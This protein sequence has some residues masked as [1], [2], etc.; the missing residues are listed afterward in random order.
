MTTFVIH[1]VNQI[2]FVPYIHINS[3]PYKG[4]HKLI[5]A[6]IPPEIMIMRE[7]FK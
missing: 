3:T 2:Y 4:K 6:I 1:W 7:T 5:F